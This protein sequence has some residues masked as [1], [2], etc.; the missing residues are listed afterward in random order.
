MNTSEILKCLKSSNHYSICQNLLFLVFNYCYNNWQN[1]RYTTHTV[2][3]NKWK[4]GSFQRR[5]LINFN[6]ELIQRVSQGSPELNNLIQIGSRKN[7]EMA[8]RSHKGWNGI[9]R[10][11]Y[12]QYKTQ[13]FLC[14]AK[15]K[16]PAYILSTFKCGQIKIDKLTR[17]PA[18]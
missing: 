14:N 7:F 9:K 6:V 4:H 18:I 8:W 2:Q 5:W 16:P 11:K 1:K 15:P 13:F 10:N 17:I 3:S 12:R